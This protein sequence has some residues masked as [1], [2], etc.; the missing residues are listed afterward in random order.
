MASSQEDELSDL[1]SKYK[2][3]SDETKKAKR[4]SNQLEK[5]KADAELALKS[6]K[7]RHEQLTKDFE[8]I[9]EKMKVR[10]ASSSSEHAAYMGE[11]VV[12]GVRVCGGVW[13]EE[14]T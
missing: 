9:K 6:L 14:N 8:A 1:A 4:T 11:C 13:R 12:G 10:H 3:A 5:Q 2:E 7:L